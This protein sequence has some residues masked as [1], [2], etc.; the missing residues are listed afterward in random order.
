MEH[1][2]GQIP[3]RHTTHWA[4]VVVAQPNAYDHPVDMTDE[5][6]IAEILCCAGFAGYVA[7]AHGRGTSGAANDDRR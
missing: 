2:R 3:T 5:P 1:A 6:R 4:P 7:A